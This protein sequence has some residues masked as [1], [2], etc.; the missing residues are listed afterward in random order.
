MGSKGVQNLTPKVT[1]FRVTLTT[2]C[3][4]MSTPM[5]DPKMGH[6]WGQNGTPFGRVLSRYQL[7]WLKIRSEVYLRMRM[8]KIWVQMGPKV[9]PKRGPFWGHHVDA[10][11]THCSELVDVGGTR[12][13]DPKI[14]IFGQKSSKNEFILG[15]KTGQNAKKR[16]P[17]LTPSKKHTFLAKK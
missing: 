17:K 9:D 13:W 11:T 1:H 15:V 2:P 7:K 16:G 4:P 3:R 14:T 12:I 8:L 10:V 5:D 6:F